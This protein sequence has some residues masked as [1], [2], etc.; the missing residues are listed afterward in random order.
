MNV[1][2]PLRA[3]AVTFLLLMLA[4]SS[5]SAQDDFK[6]KYAIGLYSGGVT[7]TDF[8]GGADDGADLTLDSGF[9]VGMQAETWLTSQFAVRM[10]GAY[11]S[12]P[13]SLEEPDGG[14]DDP[15][16]DGTFGDVK[17]VLADA[18][19]IYKPL[20]PRGSRRITPFGTVGGGIAYYNA[21][22]EPSLPEAN[23]SFDDGAQFAGSF[24]IGMDIMPNTPTKFFGAFIR[25]EVLD[26]LAFG[27]PASPL[28]GGD[29]FDPVNNLSLKL[30]M[31]IIFGLE[32][33]RR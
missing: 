17:V 6:T 3:A 23:A 27:S 21:N 29:D 14:F 18:N 20:S 19:V 1:L 26:H 8:N 31:N 12:Q 22:D 11:T 24:G 7:F 25:I 13:F 28:D 15:R 32:P 10:S 9:L 4:V 5:A 33:D 16:F 2:R 30:G